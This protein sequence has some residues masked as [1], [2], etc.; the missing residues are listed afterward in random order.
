MN[1]AVERGVADVLAAN[2]PMSLEKLSETTNSKPDRLRQILKVLYNN[3]I[4]EYEESTGLYSNNNT[5]TL[6]CSDHWTQWH[7]WVNLY[8]NQMYDIARGIPGA[9]KKDTVRTAAQINH[10][11]DLNM[12][13]YF[14]ERGWVELLHKTL[15][16][17]AHA[18]APGI[19]ADYPWDT[20]ARSGA[21][22]LDIGGGGGG[23]IASLLERFDQLR[24]GIF[25]LPHVIE[26]AK[27]AYHDNDGQYAH[28]RDRVAPDRLIGGDF[29]KSVPRSEV[30]TMKWC[31]HDWK[32]E[33]SLT[34]L[35]NIRKS[36]I[37]GPTS[38]LI[39]LETVL[40]DG[41]SKRLSRYGDIHMMMMAN[42][43]ERSE[44]QWQAL[45]AGSGWEICKIYELR[46][47]W[48]KAIEMRPLDKGY[49][50]GHDE[51]EIK[52]LAAQH[53][54][55]KSCMG[56]LLHCPINSM[57]ENMRVLDSGTA[58]GV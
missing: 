57:K 16:G 35:K 38:C 52:R 31:L 13:E 24:G 53:E 47:A 30:Y 37:L 11:T 21:E 50:M 25:D 6:L 26:H 29:L 1:A 18:M 39:I 5:S 42:G 17:G 8:G 4:F 2:G 54:W 32:D 41:R 7:S 48:V 46:N 49:E 3:T 20:L 36:I 9:I 58:D 33:D 15:G 10:D 34:I 55:I 51:A 19:L 40:A 23:F 22:I 43:Q 28:L 14:R 44:K 45:A 27:K 12:F 56:T